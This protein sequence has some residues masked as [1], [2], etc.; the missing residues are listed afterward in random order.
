MLENDPNQSHEGNGLKG[1][2]FV[3]TQTEL[4]AKYTGNKSLNN[5][6]QKEFKTEGGLIKT[7]SE[8]DGQNG[9]YIDLDYVT[10]FESEQMHTITYHVT[11]EEQEETDEIR[12]VYNLMYFSYDY[13]TYYVTLF[14]Y[15]FTQISFKEFV[16]NPDLHRAQF[17][18]VPLHDIEDIYE[19]IRH[20]LN[21][22]IQTAGK[23]AYNYQVAVGLQRLQDQPCAVTTNVPGQLCQGSGQDKHEYGEKCSMSGDKRATPGYSIIDT[24]PCCGAPGSGAPDGHGPGVGSPGGGGY[25][26]TNPNPN[27]NPQP[28]KSFPVSGFRGFLDRTKIQIS[29]GNT[30]KNSE[31]LKGIVDNNLPILQDLHSKASANREHGNAFIKLKKNGK[32]NPFANQTP[33]QLKN[34]QIGH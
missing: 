1:K 9:V 21:S 29:I 3:L 15:D 20:S 13:Q 24:R 8:G 34:G 26:P 17:A 11:L 18:V 16:M 12:E 4:E 19:N 25:T 27:P 30:N 5:I 10:V 7:N 6:L 31:V 32:F 33:L 22:A 2:S 28:I 23:T 14:R